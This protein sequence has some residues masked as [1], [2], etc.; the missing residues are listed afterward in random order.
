MIKRVCKGVLLQTL[1]LCHDIKGG[2]K[3]IYGYIRVSSQSQNIQRQYEEMKKM[4]IP[5]NQIYID[6]VSGF[7]FERNEYQKLKL[8]LKKDDLII[9]KSIDRLGRNYNAILEEWR[10]ITTIIQ[11]NIL[12]IDMPLLDTRT[13]NKNLVGKLI[14]ELVLQILS[15]VAEN[16]RENIKL[17]QFE[18]IQIAKKN[19]VVFGRPK[20]KLPCNYTYVAKKYLAKELSCKQALALTGLKKNTFYKYLPKNHM[21]KELF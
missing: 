11:A 7:H 8:K 9:I 10:Y 14:S 16:E 1:F 15:F 2:I 12:V 18:G 19:G 13:K 17:R 6:K 4:K 5:S 20:A 21:V 3:M